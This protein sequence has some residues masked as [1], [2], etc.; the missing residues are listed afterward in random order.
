MELICVLRARARQLWLEWLPEG[1]RSRWSGCLWVCVVLSPKL[2][3]VMSVMA[4][5]SEIL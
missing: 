3:Q 5:F 2:L 1:K 4:D